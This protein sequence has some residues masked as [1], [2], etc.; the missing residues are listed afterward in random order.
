VF[1]IVAKTVQHLA[2]ANNACNASRDAIMIIE[3]FDLAEINA[4]IRAMIDDATVFGSRRPIQQLARRHKSLFDVLRHGEVSWRAVADL[5]AGAGLRH[6]SGRVVTEHEWRSSYSAVCTRHR[7]ARRRETEGSIRSGSPSAVGPVG[8]GVGQRPP[9]AAR[10]GQDENR[11]V[12][13]VAFE[14][15]PSPRMTDEEIRQWKENNRK[16]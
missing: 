12:H 2:K 16:P 3:M 11:I 5:L 4:M 1:C 8:D 9:S 6:A 13:G 10:Q 7:I 15:K 14:R